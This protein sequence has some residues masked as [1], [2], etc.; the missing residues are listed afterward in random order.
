M[1]YY[2]GSTR[3]FYIEGVSPFIPSDAVEVTPE[4]KKELF[5]QQGVGWS[6]IPDGSGYPIAV[7][8]A[9]PSVVALAADRRKTRNELLQ[10]TDFVVLEDVPVGPAVLALFLVFRQALRDV[11]QQQSFPQVVTWPVAPTYQKV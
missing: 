2:S 8:P 4:Y 10:A 1:D 7:P 3:G 11:P 9:T 6:I 5:D